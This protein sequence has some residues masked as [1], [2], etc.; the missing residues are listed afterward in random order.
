MFRPKIV[1][2]HLVLIP[3]F[4]LDRDGKYAVSHTSYLYPKVV[5]V[6]EDLLYFLAAVLNSPVCHWYI[7][8]HS[9]R[10]SRGYIMLEPKTLKPVPIPDLAT[11]PSP[12]LE[13][14]VSLVKQ[15]IDTPDGVNVEGEIDEI[16]AGFY[17]LSVEEQQIIRIR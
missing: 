5:G 10:V 7:S 9:H 3:R 16:I 13:Y 8:A 2:P 1:A 12:Q 17:G 4:S 6:E 15:R 11:I 14:L